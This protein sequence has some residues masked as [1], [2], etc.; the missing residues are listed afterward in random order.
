[1]DLAQDVV[2]KDVST[3]LGVV[4]DQGGS[5]D[6]GL[7]AGTA[8]EEDMGDLAGG[9]KMCVERQSKPSEGE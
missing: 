6:L 2:G 8:P 5:L 4:K 3:G 1:M 9:R 7:A